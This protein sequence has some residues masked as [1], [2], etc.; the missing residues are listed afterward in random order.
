[1]QSSSPSEE[2]NMRALF[3]FCLCLAL[4][5]GASGQ[6]LNLD[7]YVEV[8]S[9]VKN[10]EFDTA[11][12]SYAAGEMLA[13]GDRLIERLFAL[14]WPTAKDFQAT[15]HES[16]RSGAFQVEGL[17]LWSGAGVTL[18]RAPLVEEAYNLYAGGPRPQAF[19]SEWKTT[20]DYVT[21][22]FAQ[23]AE[24]TE[25]GA[26]PE[27]LTPTYLPLATGLPHFV[28][29]Y[30]PHDGTTQQWDFSAVVSPRL[31]PG[32]LG[33][34]LFSQVQY[35]RNALSGN[36][37]QGR[38][39][40]PLP[41][42]TA[43]EGF[44]GLVMAYNAANLVAA[45]NHRDLPLMAHDG[46]LRVAALKGYDPFT[47]LHYFPAEVEAEV[48]DL[49]KRFDPKVRDSASLLRDQSAL[50][51]GLSEMLLLLTDPVIEPY[52]TAKK[53]EEVLIPSTVVESARDLAIVVYENIKGQHFD[54]AVGSF[55]SRWT[56]A[57]MPGNRSGLLN[58]E[59][60]GLVL[61]AL[62][63]FRAA[64]EADG[65][66]RRSKDVETWVKP[67][68]ELL[69]ELQA[70]D[71]SFPKVHDIAIDKVR[72]DDFSLRAHG[73]LLQGLVLSQ[74]IVAIEGTD[75]AIS[76][77]LAQLDSQWMARLQLFFASKT[78]GGL[79]TYTPGDFGAVLGGLRTYAFARKEIRAFYRM[80]SM[81][82]G[83]PNIGIL[84]SRREL[85]DT[86]GVL[87]LG[88]GGDNG[89]APVFYGEVLNRFDD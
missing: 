15:L 4:V 77:L 37:P 18:E 32:A 45:L 82:D 25:L 42:A 66:L 88:E 64:M 28:A 7:T 80:K 74:D 3:A 26:A 39:K 21:W 19:A 84:R 79:C 49:T 1:M 31:S 89:A 16:G 52:F 48:F 2:D 54:V 75:E 60:A 30:I 9:D 34:A 17:A 56:G 44:Y 47:K 71:G 10:H 22:R 78:P 27:S 51:L 62:A 57:A 61:T 5:G 14:G 41:G 33:F 11:W 55:D 87:P 72:D 40:P 65:D 23:L 46:D 83:L 69:L 29:P 38:S 24:R 43:Q 70:E 85:V 73:L 76:R 67:Q 12:A 6:D 35:A 68:V 8:E 86:P 20:N 50:L 59:D 13:S 36:R 81:L 53:D 63:R 58:L